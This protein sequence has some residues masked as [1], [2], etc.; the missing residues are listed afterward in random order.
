MLIFTNRRL[1]AMVV[2]A[3][4]KLMLRWPGVHEA[5]GFV[6]S[7]GDTTVAV[8]QYPYYDEWL[9]S[10]LLSQPSDRIGTWKTAHQDLFDASDVWDVWILA[11]MLKTSSTNWTRNKARFPSFELTRV[12]V[13]FSFLGV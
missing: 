11:R 13:S 3:K 6:A 9:Q 5:A 10:F 12:R 1:L 2:V 7:N 4:H 8:R